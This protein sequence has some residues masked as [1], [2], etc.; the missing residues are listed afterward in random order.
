VRGGSGDSTR[1][2]A[3]SP[4]EKWD[5]RYSRREGLHGYEPSPPLPA[6][7]A[8]V[9]PGLAL[10]LASGAGRHAV[11]LA[12][13]GWRVVAVDVSPVGVELTKEEARRR[14]VEDRLDARVADLES[15]PRGFRIEPDAYDLVCDFY[16]LDRTLF[17]EIR[18]GVRPG[19]L[20]VAAIHV[21]DGET[22]MNPVYLLAPGELRRIAESWG[23]E[24]LFWS[25]AA[26]EEAGH[27]HAT[28]Q[29]VARRP[30]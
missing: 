11:Y 27:H 5:D 24:V 29:I 8:G 2:G 15:S 12:G 28:S 23:W 4:R 7:V 25:E 20:F 17:D 19:G 14:G 13:L 16:F 30:G 10:D 6:A 21:D 26:S 9:R 1:P 18:A 22:G 3:Q